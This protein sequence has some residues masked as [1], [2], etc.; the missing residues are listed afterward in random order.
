MTGF[1]PWYTHLDFS[2][3]CVDFASTS[4]PKSIHT[5]WAG[6]EGIRICIVDTLLPADREQGPRPRPDFPGW[7]QKGFVCPSCGLPLLLHLSHSESKRSVFP[8]YAQLTDPTDMNSEETGRLAEVSLG[9]EC[10]TILSCL[11]L[12]VTLK[13]VAP[14]GK[15]RTKERLRRKTW[16]YY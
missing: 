1:E 13:V 3:I 9:W 11:H 8:K 14:R 15:T 2:K 12:P 4:C 7:A 16:G 10:W 6:A 5:T